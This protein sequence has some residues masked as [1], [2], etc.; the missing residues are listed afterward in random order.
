MGS[1]IIIC[2]RHRS[3]TFISHF[4]KDRAKLE[5]V[6]VFSF[7]YLLGGMS[8]TFGRSTSEKSIMHN[9]ER[10]GDHGPTGMHPSGIDRFPGSGSK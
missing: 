1:M 8:A 4:W 3:G 10:G 5:G 9:N 6:R 2:V 7:H